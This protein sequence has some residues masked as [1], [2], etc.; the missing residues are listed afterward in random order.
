[1]TSLPESSGFSRSLLDW[2][3][4][5]G[6]HDLP[7]QRDPDAYRIWVSEIMLQQTQVETVIPYFQRFIDRFPTVAA[8]A[9]AGIDDVLHLWSGLGY[10]ARARN[11]HRA[12]GIIVGK[13]NGTVPN[14]GD[15]LR[16]LPGIGRST[17]GAILA[18]AYGRRAA[19]LD[20]NV[21]RVLARYHAIEE[22]ATSAAGERQLWRFAERYTPADRVR[23]HTQAIMD[24]GAMVCTRA[25]PDCTA[26]PLRSSCA[27][28]ALGR[29]QDYPRRRATRPQPVRETRWLI[30]Q[31]HDGSVLLERRP[32]VGVW[33]GLWCLPE[34]A[35]NEDAAGSARTRLGL[36]V[37]VG[38][39]LPMLSH[40]FTH[41]RLDV[42]PL[43]CELQQGDRQLMDSPDRLW[44]KAERPAAVGIATPVQKILKKL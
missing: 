25:Q 33:G 39:P 6:R 29:P 28:Q 15:A 10:Y 36:E 30:I 26:C 12:A 22:P 7:W 19:I 11:L 9:G 41:F 23:E 35:P 34:C 37:T 43:R 17:A 4:R 20:G 3:D 38:D 16:A 42:T 8:L 24:L 13:F 21:K 5:H 44:Y 27:A 2:F 40:R 18:L 1:M 14:D 32:P 31:S